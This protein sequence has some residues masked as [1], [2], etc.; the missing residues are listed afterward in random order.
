[1]YQKTIMDYVKFVKS[2]EKSAEKNDL[3]RAKGSLF[4]FDML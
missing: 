4:V 3:F 1:M 2:Y